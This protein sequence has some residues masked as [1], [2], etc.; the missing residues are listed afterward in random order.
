MGNTEYNTIQKQTHTQPLL[1]SAFTGMAVMETIPSGSFH[2]PLVDLFG[3]LETNSLGIHPRLTNTVRVD[4]EVASSSTISNGVTTKYP[5]G[6]VVVPPLS[7]MIPALVVFLGRAPG[8]NPRGPTIVAPVVDSVPFD[9]R[10][11]VRLDQQ[12]LIAL[13][14]NPLRSSVRL[15]HQP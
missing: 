5:W 4:F 9:L 2:N 15:V 3:W 1:P 7:P 6:P 8:G 14:M 13:R 12:L 11:S 10:S